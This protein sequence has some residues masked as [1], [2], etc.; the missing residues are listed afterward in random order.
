MTVFALLSMGLDRLRTLRSERQAWQNPL[1]LTSLLTVKLV[2]PV[3]STA[4]GL[5]H[6]AAR[7]GVGA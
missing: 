4:P 7:S 6:S 5:H 3:N 2:H 1:S